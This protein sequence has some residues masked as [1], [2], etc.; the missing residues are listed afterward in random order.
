MHP[1]IARILM[2]CAVLNRFYAIEFSV[3]EVLFMYTVQLGVVGRFTLSAQ[4]HTFQFVT[5]LPNSKNGWLKGNMLVFGIWDMPPGPSHPNKEFWVNRPI[6]YPENEKRECLA[7]WV[8]KA[9]FDL[10]IGC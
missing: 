9:S 5:E 10:S 8:E 2:G 6:V 1:N 7:K 3:L 4:C